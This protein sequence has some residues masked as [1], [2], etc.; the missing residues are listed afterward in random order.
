MSADYLI[1][2]L[3]GLAFDGEAPVTMENFIL[4]VEA[5]LSA[6]DALGIKALLNDAESSHPIALKWR[7][8]DVQIR[9]TIATERARKMEKD[10]STW[11]RSSE[12]CSLFWKNRIV[13]AFNEKDPASRER[14]I[15]LARFEAAGE[16]TP[17]TAPLS[18]AAVFTYAIRLAIIIRRSSMNN[19]NGNAV[20]DKLTAAS[21]PESLFKE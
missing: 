15:D 21:S 12:G 5:Q 4:G 3:P 16:L 14:Q 2:S 11:I 10:P 17:I 9:N 7:D 1:S 18:V 19:E 6:R 20:F 8:I 13:A